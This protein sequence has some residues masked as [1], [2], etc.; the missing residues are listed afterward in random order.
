MDFSLTAEDEAFGAELRGWLDENL[1]LAKRQLKQ[2]ALD[3]DTTVQELLAEALSALF[4]KHGLPPV[5]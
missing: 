2:L 4:E 5:A 3:R 1:E